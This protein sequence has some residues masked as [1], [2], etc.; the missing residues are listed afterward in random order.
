MRRCISVGRFIAFVAFRSRHFDRVGY[1]GVGL[2]PLLRDEIVNHN[3]VVIYI[4]RDAH[5][6]MFPWIM[7]V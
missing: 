1:Q 5:S 7:E 2:W 4:Y 3:V 6:G